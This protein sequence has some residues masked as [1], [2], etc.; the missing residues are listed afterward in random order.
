M[1]SLAE[2][3][4]TNTL[5]PPS[6]PRRALPGPQT[7]VLALMVV[8]VAVHLLLLV[9]LR[10]GWLNPLFEDTMHRFG[11]GCDF[12]SI[13]AAGVKARLGESVYT[14]GG[15]VEAVPYA[16]A[17]RYAPLVAYTLGAALSMLP[18]LA[19]Y[20]L[21]LVLCEWALLRNVRLTLERA[22]DRDTGLVAASLWLLFSPYFLELYVGQFTF[23]TASLVFWACLAWQDDANRPPAGVRRR[24]GDPCWVAAIWLKMMPLLY[25][26]VALLRGRWKG[27]LVAALGLAA[28]GLYFVRFPGDWA[29][30]AATNLDA[31]P[32]WHAG[33]QGLMALLYALTG[34]R[35]RPYLWARAAALATV[36]AALSWLAARAWAAARR[37][38]DG[39]PGSAAERPLLLLY[40]AA[41][42][43]YLLTYKDVWE[44]HYVLLLPPI[45]LMAL[46]RECA[47]LW[48]PPFLVSALPGLFVFYDVRGLGYNEDPQSYWH[49]AVS[50]IQHGWKPLAAL[51]MLGGTLVVS[52]PPLRRHAQAGHMAPRLPCVARVA[53]ALA[54]LAAG[55]GVAGW[56]RAAISDQRRVTQALVWPP[57][58]FQMQRHPNTCGPAALAAVCRHYGVPATEPQVTVL[59]GTTPQGTSMLGLRDAA[60]RLGLAAEGW[61]ATVK[62]L[63]DIPRPCLLFFHRGH[64]AV[65]T[66]VQEGRFYVADPSVGQRVLTAGQLAGLWRG[67]V[68][69]VGPL[70]AGASGQGGSR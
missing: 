70:V 36:G 4:L 66:G 41:S 9:S 63:P 27:A 48:L 30:F 69:V 38:G 57:P 37:E 17:F 60:R 56:A 59:A 54:V 45:V 55:L 6:A 61:Q 62:S 43:A 19:A 25:L 47:W 67:Q 31:H 21:W 51:W 40:A 26:P 58:V 50:L 14:V 29:T 20:G 32:T 44:H 13:Y 3:M 68:L 46:R 49:P 2:P 1:L 16:Y 10:T 34:E 18:A 8:G 53:G 52:L 23:L 35:L 24:R 65:L 12:F 64:Y 5:A 39:G 28:S 11:P 7:W 42:A 15:H 33:N 22:P